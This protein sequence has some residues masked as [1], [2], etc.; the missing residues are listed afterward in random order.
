MKIRRGFVSNSSSTAFVCD[1][2]DNVESGMDVGIEEMNMAECKNGHCFCQGHT[3]QLTNEELIAWY[4]EQNTTLT[5]E[6]KKD[7]LANP[8]NIYDTIS[9]TSGVGELLYA[10]PEHL[11]PICNMENF[12]DSELLRFLMIESKTDMNTLTNMIKERFKN[13]ESFKRYLGGEK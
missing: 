3:R 8:E 1:V 7:V 6:E 11:C 9:E 12:L 10:Y 2:C 13:Y 4:F 5:E